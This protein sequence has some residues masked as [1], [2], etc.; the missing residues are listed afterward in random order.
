MDTATAAAAYELVQDAL[1]S[2]QQRIKVVLD[3]LPVLRKEDLDLDE[4]CPICLMS[5]S[6]VFAEEEERL[7]AKGVGS[8]EKQEEE[9]EEMITGVT[10]LLG[11]G[12]IFCR[13]DLTEWIR[14]QHGSCP[15]CRHTFLN[16]RPPSESDDESSDGGEYIPNPEDFDDDDE[17]VI[18]VDDTDTEDFQVQAIELDVDG[19]WAEHLGQRTDDSWADDANAEADTEMEYDDG[20]EWGLTDGESESMTSSSEGD[21]TVDES[22]DGEDENAGSALETEVNVSVHDDEENLL[23]VEEEQ[24]IIPHELASDTQEPK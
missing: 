6:A 2:P 23:D 3:S 7:M 24:G 12:H 10:K 16:I 15:T 8:E 4:P 5:L 22:N 14:N 9:G 19:I 11:C 13:R 21:M 17:D 1:L 20:S 18:D